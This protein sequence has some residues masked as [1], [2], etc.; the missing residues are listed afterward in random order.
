MCYMYFT[1]SSLRGARMF[2]GRIREVLLYYIRVA[3]LILYY[4][5]VTCLLMLVTAHSLLEAHSIM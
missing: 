5:R 2:E 4:I 3:V 1:S